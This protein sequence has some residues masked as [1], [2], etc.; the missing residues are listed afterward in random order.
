MG[1]KLPLS[2]HTSIHPTDM[3]SSANSYVSSWSLSDMWIPTSISPQLWIT[4]LVRLAWEMIGFALTGDGRWQGCVLGDLS[5]GVW[6]LKIGQRLSGIGWMSNLGLGGSK[7]PYQVVSFICFSCLL[8]LFGPISV[9]L[10]FVADW[11][12]LETW[13]MFCLDAAEHPLSTLT[14]NCWVLGTEIAS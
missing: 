8:I 12:L 13:L 14:P 1:I 3:M 2:V 4:P 6:S 7:I 10:W 9:L 11:R 5:W